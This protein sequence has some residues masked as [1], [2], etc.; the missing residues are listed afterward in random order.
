MENL[1]S[2]SNQSGKRHVS[3][4]FILAVAL[5]LCVITEIRAQVVGCGDGRSVCPH[6]QSWWLFHRSHWQ[7]HH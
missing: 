4:A 1:F 6:G 2:H 5:G 7:L 3:F